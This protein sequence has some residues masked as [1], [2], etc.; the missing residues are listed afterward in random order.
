MK[1]EQRKETSM[2]YSNGIDGWMS[3]AVLDWLFVTS[4]SMGSVVE[5]GSHKGRSTVALLSG[6]AGLVWAIDPWS[7]G[8]SLKVHN[9]FVKNTQAFPNVRILKMSSA[10]A[11]PLFE[12]KSVDMVFIDGNHAYDFVKQDIQ[13]WK[14]KARTIL[15]GH[16]YSTWPGV[17][18]AVDEQLQ[19]VQMG[20]GNIW[21]VRL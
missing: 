10:E 14:P 8:P 17:K 2:P 1:H 12:D 9:E 3:H 11:V 5:I 19:G 18:K 4:K 20:P 21:Y 13:L 7:S 16:D 6:C 15:S